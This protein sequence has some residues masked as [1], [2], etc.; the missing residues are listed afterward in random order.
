MA[1]TV[2]DV[3]ASLSR[4]Q[5]TIL[6]LFLLSHLLSTQFIDAIVRY[7]REELLNICRVQPEFE[8]NL[9]GFEFL[10]RL[11]PT[12]TPK[13]AP[14]V[15]AFDRRKTV[16]PKRR[17]GKR[18]GLHARLKA[19]A[20]KPP[21]PSLLL[22]NVR[23][24]ENKMDD[25]RARITT[26]REVRECCALIF[27]ETWLAENTPDTAVQLHAHS[28]HRGDR[29]AAASGKTKG[30]GVCIYINNR[31]CTDVQIVEKHCS[32]DIELLMV[33]CRPFYLPR[34]F[35]AVYLLSVYIP[36]RADH[37]TTLGTLYDVINQKETAHPDAVFIVAGDFNHCNLKGA[38][39]KYYHYVDFPT[40]EENILDQVYSNVKNAYKAVP[41]PHF[42]Q[43]DHVTV[44]LYPAYRQLLKRAPP[45][46][47]IIKVWSDESLQTLQDCFER[48]EWG[49]FKTAAIREDLSLDLDEYA[50]VVSGVYKHLYRE[51]I[52]TK[53]CKIYPNDKPW[54]NWEVRSM[55]RARSAAFESGDSSGYK[56]ARY[57]VRRSI[58]Q[59]QKTI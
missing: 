31:W 7:S 10:L 55:M 59:A 35:S 25:L 18:G 54:M 40:R 37:V 49:V 14:G 39:P 56:K 32:A 53:I 3:F 17:R 41:R 47:K 57:D 52:Q 42:G 23:S 11:D 51:Y 29:T 8:P 58:T 20:N 33:K 50:V 13:Q 43:S 4:L 24:L 1:P 6:F 15:D 16:H 27:T 48:T 36:P 19:R 22:A 5:Y 2:A 28:L 9:L 44:F 34:E 46:N 38:L 30:G 21:L 45:T 26:Q 12:N